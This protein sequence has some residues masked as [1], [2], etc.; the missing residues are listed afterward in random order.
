MP[1]CLLADA[2]GVWGGPQTRR[3]GR[4]TAG[5][6]RSREKKRRI[7]GTNDFFTL[8]TVCREQTETE[9]RGWFIHRIWSTHWWY[10]RENEIERLRNVL[11]EAERRYG[12]AGKS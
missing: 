9:T 12:G 3:Q 4:S 11:D 1:L 6:V 8:G 10:S 5:N 2:A 7:R